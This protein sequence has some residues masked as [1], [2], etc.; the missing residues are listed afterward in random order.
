MHEAVR[1]D[2]ELILGHGEDEVVAVVAAEGEGAVVLAEEGCALLAAGLLGD[3][4]VAVAHGLH[5]AVGDE[6]VHFREF[7]GGEVEDVLVVVDGSEG[8]HA[9]E[10]CGSFDLDFST[11]GFH[12]KLNCER[13]VGR[14]ATRNLARLP[15]PQ[16]WL[17]KRFFR[18]VFFS[19]SEQKERKEMLTQPSSQSDWKRL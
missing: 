12:F 9:V 14:V 13:S 7:G 3:V 11:M 4:D 6:G 18:S 2:V 17:I 5:L 8:H 1:Q 10:G 16:L 19:Q 15:P